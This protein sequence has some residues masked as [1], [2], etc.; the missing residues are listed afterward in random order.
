M[1]EQLANI[2]ITVATKN[3]AEYESNADVWK[4]EIKIDATKRSK[5]RTGMK[6]VNN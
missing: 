3:N 6:M 5:P 1:E 4:I 2:R